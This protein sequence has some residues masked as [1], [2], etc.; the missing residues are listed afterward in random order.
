[1]DHTLATR[2]YSG[3]EK[4]KDRITI[5]L[6]SNADSS[7]KFM[8]WVIRKSKNP[9]CFSKINRRHLRVEYRFNKTK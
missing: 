2:T 1:P 5:V 4:S 6:T 8:P 3:T 9:Q 7:E